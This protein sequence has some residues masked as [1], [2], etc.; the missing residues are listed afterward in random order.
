MPRDIEDPGWA[1]VQAELAEALAPFADKFG[2]RECAHGDWGL[3][4]AEDGECP[5][6]ETRP[7]AGSSPVVQ[8][9]VVVAVTTD[10][11]APMG[12]KSDV[13]LIDAPNQAGFVT[14]GLLWDGLNG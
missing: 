3:C 11:A 4:D 14:R 2:A 12:Q 13:V 1:R 8:H 6:E 7:K 10:L 5:F 9:F